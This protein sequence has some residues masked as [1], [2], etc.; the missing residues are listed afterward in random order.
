LRQTFKEYYFREIESVEIPS[1]I[2]EREFG[3]MPFGGNMIRHLTYKTDGD[4]QAFIVKEAP[5]SIYYSVSYY[6]EPTYAMHEKGWKGADLAFDIDCDDL[7][8]SCKKQHDMWT[9]LACR[10]QGRGTR[11]TKCDRCGG[12]RINQLNWSCDN[13]LGA[14]K[15]EAVKL[16][17]ILLGDFGLS[18]QEIKV[19]F[20]GHMGYH[21]AV[22]GSVL[23]EVDQ[24]GRVE[25]A[26]YVSGKALMPEFIGL[27]RSAR[28]EELED[29]LPIIGEPG[30]R[31][32][33]AD[34]FVNLR[35]QNHSTEE[36]GENVRKKM[37]YI[38]KV[39]GYEGLR[40]MIENAVRETSSLIDTNVTTDIH[41]IF[42]LPGTLHGETG[43]CKKRVDSIE[44]F[45]PS[46]DA[47]VLGE[48]P[49]EVEVVYAPQFKLRGQ[50]FG[51]YEFQKLKL[52]LMATVYLLG[53]GL[54][55]LV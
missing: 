7:D 33:I 19:Y 9:C 4:L 53:L 38:L 31:G 47:V 22:E 37:I 23:E 45:D 32:R 11:P 6:H 25:I 17:E 5:R 48:E 50:F 51:N 28:P 30:W 20:S 55:K 54:A 18:K 2:S 10:N 41:R 13:C 1:R 43:L 14:A 26:D 29:R 8:L 16:I 35:L 36:D 42:R 21:I 40:K 49:I 24:M 39:H 3:Y 27:Y 44:D 12:E 34:Y 15:N 46:E 52:P